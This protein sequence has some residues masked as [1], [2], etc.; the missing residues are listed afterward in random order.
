VI[1]TERPN[2]WEPPNANF[3][4]VRL[5]LV[6]ESHYRDAFAPDLTCEIVGLHG[7]GDGPGRTPFFRNVHRAFT[8][9]DARPL[10]KADF[11]RSVL[12]SNYFT[13]IFKQPDERPRSEDFA[14]SRTDFDRAL[15]ALKPD[16]FVVMSSRLWH[17]MPNECVRDETWDGEGSV[18][19]FARAG[20]EIPATHIH[21]PSSPRFIPKR[22]HD[23]LDRFLAFSKR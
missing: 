18:W 15:E 1:A 7:V 9:A 14:Q 5:L 17:A 19:R 11:W 6:G 12:F 4:G 16:A 10:S 8:G 13:R 23:K 22:W 21:H 2:P 20:Q 3:K